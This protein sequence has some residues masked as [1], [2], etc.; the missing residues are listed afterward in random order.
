MRICPQRN[1]VSHEFVQILLS[2]FPAVE[3]CMKA[4]AAAVHDQ[5]QWRNSSQLENQS[6]ANILDLCTRRLALVRREIEFYDEKM[7]RSSIVETVSRFFPL[8]GSPDPPRH[9][10]R[11]YELEVC[12]LAPPL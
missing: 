4:L 3:P 5:R 6:R 10:R 2:L 11:D 7:P 12:E 8:L 1:G 9:L